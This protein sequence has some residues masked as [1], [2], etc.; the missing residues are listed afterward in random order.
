MTHRHRANLETLLSEGR[1]SCLIQ[2]RTVL[3]DI[4]NLFMDD[5]PKRKL[6]KRIHELYPVMGEE[7]FEPV[8]ET[9]DT[10]SI[11]ESEV[12]EVLSVREDLMTVSYRLDFFIPCQS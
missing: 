2:R 8:D 5:E 7:T 10:D 9:L 11:D 1:M 3:N 4:V 12:P 6:K